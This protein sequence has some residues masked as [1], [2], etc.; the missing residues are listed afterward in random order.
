VARKYPL[1]LQ[2]YVGLLL[3]PSP[4]K[5]CV[6]SNNYGKTEIITRECEKVEIKVEIFQKKQDYLESK[7]IAVQI[8][9]R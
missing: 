5:K 9:K 3:A 4:N 2:P 1:L 6:W 7:G 8:N